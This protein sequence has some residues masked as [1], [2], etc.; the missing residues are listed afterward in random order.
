[1]NNNYRIE[2]LREE[3]IP[4]LIKLF[5][6]AR[7]IDYSLDY[8]K[9]KFNTSYTGVT[10]LA[11]LAYTQDNQPVSFF[12]LYPCFIIHEGKQELAAQSA[13]IVTH[14][15]HQRKGLFTILGNATE[16]LAIEAGIKI[17]FAF[18]NENSYPGF[19]RSLRWNDLGKMHR[20]VVEG[21]NDTLEVL[22]RK[23]CIRIGL[24]E[25]LLNHRLRKL[26]V[27]AN[28]IE[29]I[30]NQQRNLSG[31]RSVDYTAYKSFQKHHFIKWSGGVFWVKVDYTHL[32][33]GDVFFLT[34]NFNRPSF[35]DISK[36]AKRLNVSS[37]LF[38]CT[39]GYIAHHIF[40][41]GQNQQESIAI[42]GKNLV[43]PDKKLMLYFTGA[44]S[45]MF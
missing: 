22:L 11:H 36:L 6:S 21:S 39:A 44:D 10:Y 18:P 24:W 32:V 9:G 14:P 40:N 35:D 23:I 3:L 1:M 33:V 2:R 41:S 17:V 16:R 27:N 34:P 5:K 20:Y 7:N 42:V 12:C 13:D 38:D 25:R 29:G 15:M 31:I 4:D 28:E 30:Y 45:D 8:L 43:H 26:V 37:I 19:I